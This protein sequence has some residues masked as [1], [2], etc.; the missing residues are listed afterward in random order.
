MIKER[1]ENLLK[2]E[3][4]L[5]ATPCLGSADADLD[6]KNKGTCLK[7]FSAAVP[8]WLF[9]CSFQELKALKAKNESLKKYSDR[10]EP[11]INKRPC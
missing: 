6:A 4:S 2:S 8:V 7:A 11:S 9:V 3:Y 10:I 1:L 5:V